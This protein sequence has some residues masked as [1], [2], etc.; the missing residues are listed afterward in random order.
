M[1]KIAIIIFLLSSIGVHSQ[2]K[3]E[4]LI[5][6]FDFLIEELY[7]Q[8]QGIYQYAPKNEID[9]LRKT[10]TS[11]MNKLE[12]Y[13]VV[14]KVTSLTNEGHTSSS[15]PNWAMVKVGLSKSFL[16]LAVKFCDKE[17]IITQNYGTD[18]NGLKKGMK[19]L[20]ING[21][22]IDDIIEKLF[23]LIPTDGF[24][25]TSKYEWIGGI[26]LPLLYKL[27]YGK[28]RKYHLSVQEIGS[29]EI[30]NITISSIR[31]TSYKR[32]NA[33]YNYTKPESSEFI[34]RQINDS[35]AYLSIPSFGD[36][37]LDYQTFYKSTFKQID[38]L[39]IK[40]LVLDKK[41]MVAEQKVMK[42]YFLVT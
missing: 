1:K 28:T 23:P 39:N 38:S 37:T 11:S 3:P 7:L 36:D 33:K 21:E 12:F 27:T 14:R 16:P 29:D 10:I 32:K 24:N 30:K 6:D 4:K 17:L 2:N 35:I 42:I 15:L 8:H 5:Q 31:Y 19:L 13:G 20:A 9:S 34:F 40:H 25:K 18:I 41:R 26:N 22:N